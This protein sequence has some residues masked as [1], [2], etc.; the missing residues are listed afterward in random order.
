MPSWQPGWGRFPDALAA[1]WSER[2]LCTLASVRAD[3]RPHLVPVGVA[4]DHEQECAWAITFQGSRKVSV[5][6][7][8]ATASGT[9]AP[10]AASAVDRARW[11]TLEGRA[12]VLR[13]AASIER[14]CERYAS[15]YRVPKQNPNRVAIRISV[16][17]FLAAAS[18]LE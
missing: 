10:V 13:D 9:G 6:E 5:I 12:E 14:A 11:S 4:L 15:R 1:F 3:G 2:H 17:R 8:A 16:D 7:Q 18:L